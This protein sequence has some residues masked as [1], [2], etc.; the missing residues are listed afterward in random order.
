MLGQ[1]GLFLVKTPFVE[2]VPDL[3]KASY[4][5]L[6]YWDFIGSAMNAILT[7]REMAGCTD[8]MDPDNSYHIEVWRMDAERRRDHRIN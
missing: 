8:S 2:D 6:G 5:L 1:I 3:S 4:H 7:L